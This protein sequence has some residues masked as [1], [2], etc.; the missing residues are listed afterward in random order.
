MGKREE[1]KVRRRGSERGGLSRAVGAQLGY[2]NSLLRHYDNVITMLVTCYYVSSARIDDTG[3]SGLCHG[4]PA[5]RI[6]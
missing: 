6:R 3:S 5:S 4:F 2:V 1:E